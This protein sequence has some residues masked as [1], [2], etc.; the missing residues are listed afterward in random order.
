MFV[1][2]RKSTFAYKGK[3]VK[4]KQ[5]S[6]EL[7]VRYVLEGSF[8]KKDD[9]LRITAQLIDA[10]TGHHLWSERYDRVLKDFFVLQ[11]EITKDILIALQV[12]LTEGEQARVWGK[13]TRNF[14]AYMKQT[15]GRELL[16]RFNI[17]DLVRSRQLRE[18]AIALDP[19]FARAIIG[20][21]WVHLMEIIFGS[22]KSP[23]ESMEQA[24]ELA[25]K[26]LTL[27]PYLTDV[28]GILGYINLMKGQHEKAIAQHEKAVALA[29]NGAEAHYFLAKSLTYGG[30]PEKAIPFFEKALRLNPLSAGNYILNLGHAYRIMGRY[31]EALAEYEKAVHLMPSYLFANVNLTATYSLLNREK[32]ALETA[33]KVLRMNPKFSVEHFAKNTPFKNQ[34]GKDRYLEGLYRAG[35]K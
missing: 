8:Q 14:E 18:E 30:R 4:I 15:I 10:T 32:E 24:E 19:E 33:T 5:V 16:L 27:E 23:G 31:E 35:L 26:A 25:Q 12:K 20:L 22:S 34:A 3:P 29:P 13:G 21:A 2:A 28:Y 6:E 7:G 17:E 11:D 1:I 9:R